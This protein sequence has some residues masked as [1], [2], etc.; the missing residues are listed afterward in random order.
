[1]GIAEGALFVSGAA[2]IITVLKTKPWVKA[3]GSSDGTCPLHGT[4]VEDIREIKE[5]VKTLIREV[6][7]MK[8]GRGI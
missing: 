8:S 7:G 3:N 5:D 4:L 2:V 1:M 6:A